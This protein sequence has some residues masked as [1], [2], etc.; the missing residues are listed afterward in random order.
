MC[1]FSHTRSNMEKKNLLFAF[2]GLVLGNTQVK[3]TV[4]EYWVTSTSLYIPKQGLKWGNQAQYT[5]CTGENRSF[6]LTTLKSPDETF[7]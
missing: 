7:A 4:L 2:V 1:F 5:T 3:K 6:D